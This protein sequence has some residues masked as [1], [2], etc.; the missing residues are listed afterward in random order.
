[1]LSGAL[2]LAGSGIAWAADIAPIDPAPYGA[3]EP[4]EQPVGPTLEV[5]IAPYFWMAGLSGDVA[6][7]GAPAVN[8]DANFSDILDNLDFG[9]MLVGE[10][11][12]GRF[13]VFSDFLYLKVSTGKATPLGFLANSLN[14][15]AETLE[16]TVA[17]SYALIETERGHL[18]IL[19]GARL[20]SVNNELEIG[21]GPFGGR[22]A[23]DSATWVDAI[24]G[25]RGRTFVTDH[26][27]LTGW[28]MVGAGGADID[29]DLLGGLGYQFTD[30]FS[31][32]IGY[33]AAGVDY[34]D[35]PFLFDV[36]IQGPVLGAVIRF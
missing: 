33:R 29:W 27:Y 4:V 15:T 20:W 14:L 24:V 18:D 13:G 19:A 16:W 26:L 2:F 6:A 22:S 21:G 10:A 1:M 34:S 7:F 8:V 30:H 28:A 35:G 12:Y 5:T 3:P 36:V 23:S 9:G 17:G 25:V 32:V 11:R 31:G